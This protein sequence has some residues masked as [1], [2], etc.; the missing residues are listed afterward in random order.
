VTYPFIRFIC[1]YGRALSLW[2]AVLSFLATL[3]VSYQGHSYAWLIGGSVGSLVLG[4]TLRLVSEIV[5]VVADA[6]LP[7]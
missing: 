2:S 5:E 7:R 6:L 1:K 4:A 3:F